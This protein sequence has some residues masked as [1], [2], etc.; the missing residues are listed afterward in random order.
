MRHEVGQVFLFLEKVLNAFEIEKHVRYE[1][2]CD[3]YYSTVCAF[4]SAKC[5]F[6]NWE[7]AYQN[8]V[9]FQRKWKESQYVRRQSM[10]LFQPTFH[11]DDSNEQKVTSK[12]MANS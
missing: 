11:R 9:T 10:A 7:S 1:Y 8:V 4:G 2:I 12:K 3:Y 5:T 6:D